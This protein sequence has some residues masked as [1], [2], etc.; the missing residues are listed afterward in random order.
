MD[1]LTAIKER[2]SCRAFLPDPV[3]EEA[4]DKIL[5][6]ATWAPSPMNLQPWEF[7]VITSPLI[8]HEIRA[9]AD[10]R[11]AELLEK[12][13]WKWLGRYRV[14]FLESAPVLIAV[15][16]DPEKSGADKFLDG[17][18]LCYQHAC[19][20]AVQNMLLCAHAEGLGSLWYTLYDSENLRKIL[21]LDPGKKPFAIIC[22][23]RPAGEPLQT[24]RKD[25]AEKTVFFS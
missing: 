19:A 6:A 14:D 4:I 1:V 16:G 10:V 22:I 17:G 5:E 7:V 18:G 25:A 9:E 3:S 21:G 13:G 24:P 23:G 12:S 15:I 8:K 2:R 20:A 11:R